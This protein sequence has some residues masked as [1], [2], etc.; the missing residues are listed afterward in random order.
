MVAHGEFMRDVWLYKT[1]ALTHLSKR[2]LP[3]VELPQDAPGLLLALAGF[4]VTMLATAR[5]GMVRTYFG[6]ELGFVKPQWVEGFPY[7]V[8]PHPMIMGQVFAYASIFFWWYDRLSTENMYLL[9]GH[10]GCYSFHM[11]QEMLTSSY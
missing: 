11:V 9:A 4:S 2:L 8:I 10:I 3:L 6:S 5:L 7:G 1:I